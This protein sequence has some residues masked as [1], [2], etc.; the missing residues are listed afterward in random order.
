M[1]VRWLASEASHVA[2]L[3]YLSYFAL[4]KFNEIRLAEAA[5]LAAAANY[6]HIFMQLAL[7]IIFRPGTTRNIFSR[8]RHHETRNIWR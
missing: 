5:G 7:R 3:Y 8:I 4:I 2:G 1:Q 6:G